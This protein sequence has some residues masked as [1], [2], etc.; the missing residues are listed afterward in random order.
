MVRHN[1]YLPKELFEQVKAHA[2]AQGLPV[3]EVL[4][5]ALTAHLETK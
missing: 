1:F 2:A 5:R 3:S 4:R